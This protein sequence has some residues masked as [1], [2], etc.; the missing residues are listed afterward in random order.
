MRRSFQRIVLALAALATSGCAVV[1][2][3]AAFSDVQTTIAGRVDQR[4]E[5]DPDTDVD[6]AISDVVRGLLG[7]ELTADT[8]IQVALLNNRDLQ[9]TFEELG[10]ARADL[11]QAGLLRNPVFLA[12]RRFAGQAAEL[13]LMQELVTLVTIPLRKRIAGAAFEAAKLRV[14]QAILDLAAETR[15]AFYRLQGTEQMVAMRRQV[16]ESVGAS[17]DLAER[18][19]AAGNITDLN[20][21]MEQRLEHEA[22]LELTVVEEDVV[23]QRERLNALMGLWGAETTWSVVPRLPDL[24][25]NETPLQGLESVAA[26]QRFDLAAVRQDIITS[27]EALGLTKALRWLPAA[28]LGF[29]YEHEPDGGV[30]SIGPSIEV[31]L[32]V[33]DWGQ[34]AVPRERALLRQKQQRYIALAVEIRSRVRAA[35]SRMRTARDRAE[36][37]RQTVLP[38]HVEILKQAQLQ[39]NAMILGPIQLLQQKQAEID[40]G[41]ASIEAQRDYWVARTELEHALGGRIKGSDAGPPTPSPQPLAKEPTPG[42]EHQHHQ[43]EAQP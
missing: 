40:A 38:L 8:A 1:S 23:Q 6:A 37:Y 24:P 9:A 34:A 11:V 20:R 7:Q 32:P 21:R 29:H 31:A 3:Q 2:K 36:F 25:P 28:S 33:F 42:R 4:V 16:A 18:M 19:Y 43:M 13:D 41:R 10:I 39:Y 26:A 14:S 27:A 12:E 17:A 22:R 15:S 35:Y 5:W 30:S